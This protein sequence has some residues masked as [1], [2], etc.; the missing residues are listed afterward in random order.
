MVNLVGL[1]TRLAPGLEAHLIRWVGW[2]VYLAAIIVLC[3][4]WTRSQALDERHFGLAVLLSVF[5]APHLHYH[6][7]TLLLIPLACNMVFVVREGWVER[8]T[9]ALLP[10][11]VS[12]ALLLGS[13]API[14]KY[15]LPY[16]VMVFLSVSLW[17][18][19]SLFHQSVFSRSAK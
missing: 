8:K 17:L 1:L 16:L 7:L 2:G 10:L 19:N 4:I 9:A 3:M 11:A 5:F 18:P 6:D 15:N 14:L 13:L 12:L